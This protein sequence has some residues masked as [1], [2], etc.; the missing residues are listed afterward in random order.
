MRQQFEIKYPAR[1]YTLS[2]GEKKTFWTTHGS[3]WI[4]EERKNISVK[5][6]SLPVGDKFNGYFRAFPYVP[7][8]QQ[9]KKPTYEG[10]P[11]D[12]DLDNLDDLPF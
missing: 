8:H 5:I 10:L 11:A 1:E 3:I 2:N 4:D 12:D 7:K 6:D 9:Q